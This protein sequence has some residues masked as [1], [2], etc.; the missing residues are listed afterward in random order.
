MTEKIKENEYTA[1]SIKVLKGL[2]AVKKRPGMYIGDVCDG[3]GLHHMVYEVVDNSVDESFAGHCNKII[4]KIYEDESVSVE[5]NG[6]GIPVDM[7]EEGVSAAQIIMTTLHAGGKFDKDSYKISGGL[8]G[9]GVSVVNAL[10]TY[11]ELTIWRDGKEHFMKFSNGDPLE[12]I[13]V[14]GDATKKRGTYVRFWPNWEIFTNVV[15]FDFVTLEQKFKELAFLNSNI[16][17]TLIDARKGKEKQVTLAYAGGIKEYVQYITEGK[18]RLHEPIIIKAEDKEAGITVDLGILWTSEE[19]E[20]V[21]CFTNN[22]RQRDGGTHLSGFKSALTR[23]VNSYIDQNDLNKKTKIGITGEDIR[24]GL[25]CVLSV[26]V[27]NPKFSSQTKDKLVSYEVRQAVEGVSFEKLSKWFEENPHEARVICA[28]VVLAAV[29]REESRKI[30]DLTKRK[31]DFDKISNLPGKLS[32]CQE[33]SP[34]LAELFIVEGDSAGGSAKQGRNRKYQAV[35]PIR[36]KI[37]NVEKARFDKMLN[38][39]QV[40]TLITALGAGIADNFSADKIRYHKIIIMTDA[41]VDGSHIRTLL[42]T[43]FYRHMRPIIECGYLYFAQPPLYKIKQGNKEKYIKDDAEYDSFIITLIAQDIKV[44]YNEHIF[45]NQ[46]AQKFIAALIKFNDILKKLSND[47]N[48]QLLEIIAIS[49][50]FKDSNGQINHE[51]LLNQDKLALLNE[52]LEKSTADIGKSNWQMKRLENA[53]EFY[54]GNQGV[55]QRFI[56]KDEVVLNNINLR[57]LF[58]IGQ[59]YFSQSEISNYAVF[60]KDT[61]FSKLAPSQLYKKIMDHVKRSISL[62]RFKGLGEMDADELSETTMK[63]ENR[64]LYKVVIED[65]VK[66][67]TVFATLMGDDVEPRR[68]FIQTNALNATNID[69]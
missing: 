52:H 28:K 46:E 25:S 59:E 19:K 68:N 49:G 55:T 43:F 13:K 30:R 54:R 45:D 7:H 21:L 9:L 6:R 31:G 16:A 63:A 37:L 38:S 11:L 41:D 29:A 33:R 14:V 10:S 3:S 27:P 24:E 50:I 65:A 56:I 66:A 39:D 36:G 53:I 8:H 44:S 32:D 57:L 1:D 35:L 48:T 42:L 5:D 40:G 51:E 12:P 58:T 34:A 61:D 26:K 20:D 22:I 67:E 69:I 47:F 2:E 64:T 23:V 17:I 15:T 62:Q 60:M 4:V 18:E